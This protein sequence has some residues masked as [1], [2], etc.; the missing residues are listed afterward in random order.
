AL[1][2][3]ASRAPGS[4]RFPVRLQVQGSRG[5]PE[6][7][8]LCGGFD[9]AQ[10][11]EA[12]PLR[13]P[14]LVTGFVEALLACDRRRFPARLQRSAMVC[15]A[16]PFRLAFWGIP[17]PEVSLRCPR[18]ERAARME[19]RTEVRSKLPAATRSSLQV[20]K[21][22]ARQAEG[23]A[24]RR[25]AAPTARLGL[26]ASFGGR[27]GVHLREHAELCAPQ[28]WRKMRRKVR[29][30]AAAEWRK[31]HAGVLTARFAAHEKALHNAGE[32]MDV[33]LLAS[34]VDQ[35]SQLLGERFG[36]QNDG[37]ER[38]EADGG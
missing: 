28:D 34:D 10:K 11:A 35:L 19:P 38:D 4:R 21:L 5:L 1:Y 9:G 26:L 22:A 3:A 23:R 31:G 15:F 6:L 25:P 27:R 37:F 36:R 24:S 29:L 2:G 8:E 33:A 7:S 13:T 20:S 17:L 16:G 12:R 14:K 30:Q 18:V 32:K